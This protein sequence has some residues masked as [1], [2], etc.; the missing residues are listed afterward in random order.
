MSGE[1]RF[2]RAGV[3]NLKYDGPIVRT[4]YL[5]DDGSDEYARVLAAIEETGGTVMEPSARL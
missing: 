5:D 4:E 2:G 3:M 1:S